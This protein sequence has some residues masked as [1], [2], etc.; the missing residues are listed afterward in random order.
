MPD[1]QVSQ[2]PENPHR[3]DKGF[4]HSCLLLDAFFQASNQDKQHLLIGAGK[5][6]IGV[7]FHKLINE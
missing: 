7:P 2:S 1:F 3:H 5:L 6:E 4:L